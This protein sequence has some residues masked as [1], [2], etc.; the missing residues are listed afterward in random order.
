LP[1][2]EVKWSC[3]G[4]WEEATIVGVVMSEGERIPRNAIVGGEILILQML[5]R[6]LLQGE[7]V[8]FVLHFEDADWDEASTRDGLRQSPASMRIA[9]AN[10]PFEHKREGTCGAKKSSAPARHN[11]VAHRLR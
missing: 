2:A 4:G 1:L 3:G 7:T 10:M 5:L 6:Q 11:P 8:P 9:Y